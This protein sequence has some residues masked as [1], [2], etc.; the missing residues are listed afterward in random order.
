[1]ITSDSRTEHQR[2]DAKTLLRSC[3]IRKQKSLGE[4]CHVPLYVLAQSGRHTMG[5][6]VHAA[7]LTLVAHRSLPRSISAAL[8]H[9]NAHS[10]VQARSHSRRGRRVWRQCI[11]SLCAARIVLVTC[12]P[13][14]V[15]F[16]LA[17]R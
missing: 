8:R 5:C 15:I 13:K 1:M 4:S 9:G 17:G 3:E 11:R 12:W 2:P 14:F 10:S 16:S 6:C 7:V